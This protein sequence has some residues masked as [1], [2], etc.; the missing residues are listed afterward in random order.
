MLQPLRKRA[1]F[2]RYGRLMEICCFFSSLSS[3]SMKPSTKRRF[4]GRWQTLR[5]RR[6]DGS[7]S[8]LVRAQMEGSG[9]VIA[10]NDFGGNSS[11]FICLGIQFSAQQCY[12][13][14]SNEGTNY[15]KYSF[16]AYLPLETG[17]SGQGK[18][19][20]FGRDFVRDAVLVTNVCIFFFFGK[21]FSTEV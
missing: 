1:G 10:H 3:S 13:C 14:G 20:L 6:N 18:K 15:R 5:V 4:S 11:T 21:H 7:R 12:T 19:I 17:S 9:S 8:R 16:I 2:Y